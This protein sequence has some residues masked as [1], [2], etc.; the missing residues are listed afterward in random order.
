V[1]IQVASR[2]G[3][4]GAIHN[5]GAAI[6]WCCRGSRAVKT[7][8]AI[9]CNTSHSTFFRLP[10]GTVPRA[11]LCSVVLAPLCVSPA[12]W[13]DYFWLRALWFTM[14]RARELTIFSSSKSI[15]ATPHLRQLCSDA[16]RALCN[17]VL[18]RRRRR[19]DI[20]EPYRPL[21]FG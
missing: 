21:E 2:H 13:T 1:G 14:S 16:R 19:Q 20:L 6:C 18:M 4:R 9:R 3:A 15:V 5:S 7:L 10:S 11:V 8:K 12:A 17:R